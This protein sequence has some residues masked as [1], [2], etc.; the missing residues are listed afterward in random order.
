MIKK[1]T[2]ENFLSFRVPT[3]ISLNPC[4]NILLGINGSGKSNFLNSI[5]LLYESVIGNGLKNFINE[6]GGLD[7]LKNFNADKKDDI[8]LSFEF[9]REAI[10]KATQKEGYE[11]RINPIYDI[12]IK[13]GITSYYLYEDLHYTSTIS[14][15]KTIIYLCRLLLKQTESVLRQIPERKQYYPLATLKRALAGLSAYYCSAYYCYDTTYNSPVSQP[16]VYSTEK[17]LLSD[18]QNLANILNNIKNN[19]SLHYEKIEEAMKKINPYFKGIDFG[20][21]SGGT[22]RYLLLLSILYNPDRGGLVCINEPET[23]LHP[24]MINTISEAIKYASGTSQIIIT[25]HSPLLLNSFD[26]E[27][28]LIFEKNDLNQTIVSSKSSD[29]CEEWVGDI[30]PGQAWL[31]G[32]IGGKRW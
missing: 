30:L 26:I 18:G 27:D 29:E 21:I 2:L 15:M 32:L 23:G 1:I 25:T 13:S 8:K 24:D 17:K 11:F 22:F 19:H 28:I 6:N 4:V 16:V 14:L 20:H 3:S 12:T 7:S 31:Q 9:D 10:K 5:R